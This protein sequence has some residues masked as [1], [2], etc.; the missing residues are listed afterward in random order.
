MDT[1]QFLVQGS[2]PLAYEVTFQKDTDTRVFRAY[3]TCP[4][5]LNGQFCKHRTSILEANTK[6]IVSDNADQVAAV[7]SW[8]AGTEAETA[9]E[10]VGAA[11]RELERAKLA[12]TNGKKTLAKTM[13]G[14]WPHLANFDRSDTPLMKR[15]KV[16]A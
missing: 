15:P 16:M 4:A 1:I 3:C 5:G 2:A 7:V 6:G 13:L 9:F 14:P 11:G 10:A 8:L 12:L